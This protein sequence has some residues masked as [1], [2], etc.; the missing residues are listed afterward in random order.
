MESFPEPLKEHSLSAHVKSLLDR[1]ALW[2][3]L[4]WGEGARAVQPSIL[5]GSPHPPCPLRPRDDHPHRGMLLTRMQVQ[6][7]ACD[8]SLAEKSRAA[9]CRGAGFPAERAPR[10]V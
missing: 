8:E 5:T 1:H 4:P 10:W 9:A 3:T 7:E 2:P 6:H